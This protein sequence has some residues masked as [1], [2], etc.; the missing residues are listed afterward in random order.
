MRDKINDRKPR[1]NIKLN[2]LRSPQK[3]VKPLD[4][5]SPF[6]QTRMKICISSPTFS[7]GSFNSSVICNYARV[8]A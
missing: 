1:L 8:E 5:V 2:H 6:F 3:S 7:N 4:F